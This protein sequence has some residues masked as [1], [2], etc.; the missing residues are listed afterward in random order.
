MLE[1][2]HHDFRT[3]GPIE[4]NLGREYLIEN[5]TEGI[6]VGACIQGQALE[7]L[8]SHEENAAHDAGLMVFSL[9]GRRAGKFSEAKVEDFDLKLATSQPNHHQIAGLQ[10]PVNQAHGLRGH[11]PFE[12][13]SDDFLKIRQ[14]E[15]PPLGELIEGLAF[16]ILHHYK[17]PLL[18]LPD[19]INRNDV[20]VL[21][22]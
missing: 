8:R 4:G 2:A 21:E 12:G 1:M 9:A 6:H 3:R 20:R 22:G 13:L 19:I 16:E 17:R 10:V 15:R 18:I 11:H 14:G 5:A 7:L